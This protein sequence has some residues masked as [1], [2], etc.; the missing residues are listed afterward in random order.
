MDSP[1]RRNEEGEQMSFRELVAE[2]AKQTGVKESDVRLVLDS[3]T[4]II[5]TELMKMNVVNMNTLGRFKCVFR[6][7]TFRKNI[8]TGEHY[9][10]PSYRTARFVPS[11]TGFPKW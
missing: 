4:R 2:I 6:K 10:V 5:K 1:T 11:K 7:A 3:M 8:K 9:K